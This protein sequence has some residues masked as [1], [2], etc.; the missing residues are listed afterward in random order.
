[1]EMLV[2]QLPRSQLCICFYNDRLAF[3]LVEGNRAELH[4]KSE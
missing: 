3:V 2:A 1:M 4:I